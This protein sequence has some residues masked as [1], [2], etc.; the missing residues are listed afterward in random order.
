MEFPIFQVDVFT[1]D[2]FGGNPA[3][4]AIMSQWLPDETLQAIRASG[5]KSLV[6]QSSIYEGISSAKQI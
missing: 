6:V 5:C 4:V 3:A 1:G 2:L